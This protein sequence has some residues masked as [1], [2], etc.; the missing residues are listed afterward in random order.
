MLTLLMLLSTS[1]SCVSVYCSDFREQ[2]VK[3]ITPKCPHEAEYSELHTGTCLG[4]VA[5]QE[6]VGWR[7]PPQLFAGSCCWVLEGPTWKKVGIVAVQLFL[8]CLYSKAITSCSHWNT[9]SVRLEPL[10]YW[11]RIVASCNTWKCSVLLKASFLQTGKLYWYLRRNTAF[12]SS[13]SY[14]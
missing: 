1:L 10:L 8:A 5:H 9:S 4:A 7:C 12:L 6:Q 2:Q 14:V 11:G 13:S 3:L